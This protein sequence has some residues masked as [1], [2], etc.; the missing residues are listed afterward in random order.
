MYCF[1]VKSYSIVCVP[2]NTPT[3]LYLQHHRSNSDCWESVVLC[4]DSLQEILNILKPI[5]GNGTSDHSC[6]CNV[7]LRQPPSHRNLSSHTVSIT[8]SIY[9]SLHDRTFRGKFGS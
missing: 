8:L 4:N 7:S 1:A 3:V 9:H 6:R 5:V 2:L